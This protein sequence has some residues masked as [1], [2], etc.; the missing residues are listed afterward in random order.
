MGALDSQIRAL[1][2]DRTSLLEKLDILR[3]RRQKELDA[4]NARKEQAAFEAELAR[5][6]AEELKQQNSAA[7]KIQKELKAYVK[8]KLEIE[9]MKPAK[10]GKGGGKGK[11]K[12]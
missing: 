1:T 11:K 12:K 9:A 4:E 7:K 5:Q 2:N 3:A 8:R 6:Q 10:K